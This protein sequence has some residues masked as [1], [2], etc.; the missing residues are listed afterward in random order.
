MFLRRGMILGQV[1]EMP[2]FQGFSCFFS[3][4]TKTSEKLFW[5]FT[6]TGKIIF[7]KIKIYF[8]RKK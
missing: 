1:D 7:L 5:K 8:R 2:I 3:I 6:F 4:Y